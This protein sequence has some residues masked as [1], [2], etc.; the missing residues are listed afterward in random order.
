[1]KRFKFWWMIPKG[2]RPG[3]GDFFRIGFYCGKCIFTSP[4][5]VIQYIPKGWSIRHGQKTP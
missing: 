5:L 3:V 4:W 1:M 2:M